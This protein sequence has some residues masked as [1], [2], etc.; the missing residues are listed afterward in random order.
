MKNAA[1]CI[2]STIGDTHGVTAEEGQKVYELV[3][4]AIEAGHKV[5]LSFQN[6]DLLTVA[7]LNTA[8]GQLYR[9]FTEEQVKNHLH[10]TDISD[11]GKVALRRVVNTAKLIYK[12]PEALRISMEEIIDD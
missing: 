2:V 7:F 6:I 12:D 11:S 3:R 8:I 9:E 10:F 5:R 4:K 1:I